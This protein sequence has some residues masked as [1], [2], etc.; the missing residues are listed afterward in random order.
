MPIISVAAHHAFG[1]KWHLDDVVI[2]IKGE[3][4]ILWGAVDQK[5]WHCYLNLSVSMSGDNGL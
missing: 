3:H 4:H 5:V 1:D 2:T